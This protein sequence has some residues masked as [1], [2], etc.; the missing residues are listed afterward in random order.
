M[1]LGGLSL[2]SYSHFQFF[3]H[4]RLSNVFPV[5]WNFTSALKLI[6]KFLL[7]FIPEGT[8][9]PLPVDFFRRIWLD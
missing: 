2:D 7:Q 3:Q 1:T 6:S 5:R 8:H 9:K 4:S